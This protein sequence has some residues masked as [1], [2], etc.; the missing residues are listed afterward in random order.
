MTWSFDT[1]SVVA[2]RAG[3]I[4]SVCLYSQV[5]QGM[6]C[7]GVSYIGIGSLAPVR[8]SLW[9]N[10]SQ[11][12]AFD[13]SKPLAGTDDTENWYTSGVRFDGIWNEYRWMPKEQLQV[14][15]YTDIY[16][17]SSQTEDIN[18]YIY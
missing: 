8:W 1:P 3:A 14:E 10:E 6:I 5:G 2:T 11:K 13:V 16:R 15:W 9:V 17:F 18:V 4:D 12:A 7:K